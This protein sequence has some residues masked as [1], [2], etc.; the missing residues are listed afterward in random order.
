MLKLNELLVS[1]ISKTNLLDN[2]VKK[3]SN[4][5][6]IT[7][8]EK[9]ILQKHHNNVVERLAICIA[10]VDNKYFKKDGELFFSYLH[11]GQYLIYLYFFSNSLSKAGEDCLKNKLYYLNKILNS[12]DIYP[13]VELPEIFFFEHPLGLVLGRAEYGNNFFAM[14][15]C[16]VGGNKS[17]YPKIGEN[18][19]M[20][21]NSKILGNSIIGNN[22]IIAA[23][24]YIKDTHISD[25]S[26]VFGQYPNNIIKKN[27]L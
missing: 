3:L 17:A 7:E 18:V 26:V 22:V 14:Q 2:L 4:F 13:D 9:A 10:G 5:F 6:V 19:K 27:D 15:G 1:D 25:N 8:D 20:Y 21:S 23:N 16:T 11:S 24:T 12:V